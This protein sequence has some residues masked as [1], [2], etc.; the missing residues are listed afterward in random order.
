MSKNLSFNLKGLR[1]KVKKFLPVLAKHATFI[2][3]MVVLVT[4]LFV[5]WRISQLAE[6]EPP[7]GTDDVTAST[8]PKI[9]KNAIDQI[10][11]LEQ[12]S[13]EVKSFFDSAR[14]NPFSE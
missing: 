7:A 4:Y 3:L 12:S 1:L 2:I 6:A 5:V 9:D 10:Q 14:N 11:A 8:I 13:T